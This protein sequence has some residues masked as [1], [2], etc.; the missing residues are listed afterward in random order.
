MTKKIVFMGTPDFSV[1][2]L[3]MLIESDY[4]VVAVVTQPD[5]PRGRK[6]QMTPSP[7]K[8]FA[9]EHGVPVIQPVKIRTDFEEILQYKPDLIVTAAYGQILPKALLDVP[10]FGCINVHASL[11]PELRGG[12][13]IHYAIMQGKKETG[14]TIMYMAEGMDTGDMIS[15]EAIRID[16]N[17]H[18]GSLHD[19]LSIVGAG[20]LK[21]TL[22]A[23]FSNEVNATPQ[24]HEKATY[25]YT[26]KRNEEK[27]DWQKTQEEIYNHIRG[28]HPWPVAY[29]TYKDQTIKI[30]WAEK[31]EQTSNGKPGEIL[32]VEDG[33]FIGT[34]DGKQ[35]N[36]TELQPSGKKRM[37]TEDFLRGS[38]DY[39]TVGEQLG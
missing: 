29:T 9:L 8:A 27:I 10:P 2:I 19:K 4:E 11:L 17:D 39:F 21:R 28:L 7:V 30:W 6:R 1:P 35:L 32:R 36:I 37:K 38:K 24:D 15:Q 31:V 14:V 16:E 20:L 26:I 34:A 12:A 13:P 18:T 22:P 33:L 3:K 23:I 25:A 5:K